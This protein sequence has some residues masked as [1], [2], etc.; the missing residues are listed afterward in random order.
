MTSIR[1]SIFIVTT[2]ALAVFALP[3][4]A[5]SGDKFRLGMA[6]A[7]VSWGAGSI[8]ATITNRARFDWLKSF[9]ITVPGAVTIGAPTMNK[10]GAIAVNSGVISGSGL[11]VPYNGSVTVTIPATFPPSCGASTDYAWNTQAFGGLIVSNEVFALDATNSNVKTTVGASTCTIS[12]ATQPTDTLSNL[13]ITSAPFNSGGPLVQAKL[14]VDTSPAPNG[15]AVSLASACPISAGSAST[16]GG[17]GIAAFGTLTSGAGTDCQLTATSTGFT[18]A[19]S[20][21]F[22][23]IA[24]QG[25]ALGCTPGSTGNAAGGLN[26]NDT[27][28][29][30]SP[31]YG[32]IRVDNVTGPCSGL[33]WAF[34]L[35]TTNHTTKFLTDKNGQVALVEYVVLWMPAPIPPDGWPQT[36]PYVSWGVTNPVFP[37]DYIP[38]LAC[39]EDDVT[40]GFAAVMPTIP[41]VSPYAGNSHPQ[42][43]PNQPAQM[44]IA[45]QGWSIPGT[46]IIQQWVKVIDGSD[47]F[48]H[49]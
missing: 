14:M 28:F 16:A 41:S 43:L 18:P 36:R 20:N 4:S 27:S 1:K 10:P 31:D 9:K 5:D 40:L 23:I 37:D 24:Q 29:I 3:A 38:A 45:Q 42:F 8:T 7:S 35:D 47:G 46:G 19:T 39:M 33:P 49:Q 17:N 12:F 6:P 25:P 48:T 21:K 32:L 44:C 26:V 30:G 15:I 22:N 11:L 34:T 13:L 2:M